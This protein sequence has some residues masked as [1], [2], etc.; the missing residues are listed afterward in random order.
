MQRIQ[1]NHIMFKNAKHRYERELDMIKLLKSVRD[2]EN[3]R[4]MFLTR[5]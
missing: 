3:F 5:P 2:G 1:T 4:K